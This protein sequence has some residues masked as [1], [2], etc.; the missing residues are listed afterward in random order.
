MW[1]WRIESGTGIICIESHSFPL[2]EVKDFLSAFLRI[3]KKM[4]YAP[5]WNKP[6]WLQMNVVQKYD[7][8][9]CVWRLP[10]RIL[11]AWSSYFSAQESK[12]EMRQREIERDRWISRFTEN[13]AA[14]APGE[15][16][17]INTFLF[18]LFSNNSIHNFLQ[19]QHAI[20]MKK[21]CLYPFL[22]VSVL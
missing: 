1:K 12:Y 3:S 16:A 13:A 9:P 15:C 20:N 5:G 4:T 2:E 6:D 14:L 21:N 8:S 11:L 18:N 19:H 7:L 22:P 17:N 10:E